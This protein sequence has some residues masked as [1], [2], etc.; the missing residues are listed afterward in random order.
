M[1]PLNPSVALFKDFMEG[2]KLKIETAGGTY[3]VRPDQHK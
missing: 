1:I 2:E 3:I